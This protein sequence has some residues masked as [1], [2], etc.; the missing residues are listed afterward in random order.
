MK[1]TRNSVEGCNSSNVM[2]SCDSSPDRRLLFA[3]FYSLAREICS[4]AIRPAA[5]ESER[6][7]H[8]EQWLQVGRQ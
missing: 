4:P 7:D 2:G 8:V 1:Y 5:I 3:I 6:T